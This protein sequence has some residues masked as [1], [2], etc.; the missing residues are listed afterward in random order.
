MNILAA[1]AILSSWAMIYHLVRTA[2]RRPATITTTAPG[3][4]DGF[5]L[6]F[7]EG[8]DLDTVQSV[9]PNKGWCVDLTFSDHHP[10]QGAYL[11]GVE[12]DQDEGATIAWYPTDPTEPGE[13]P[14][15]HIWDF[16]TLTGIT[17]L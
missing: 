9:L 4:F 12:W 17:V 5:V 7:A 2:R 8:T 15:K 3:G 13:P 16:E 11:I 14:V 6:A 1:I 10:V